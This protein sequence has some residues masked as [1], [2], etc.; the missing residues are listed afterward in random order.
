MK[1]MTIKAAWKY[2]YSTARQAARH[3]QIGLYYAETARIDSAAYYFMLASNDI[4]E[5][6]TGYRPDGSVY[7]CFS[8]SG[9]IFNVYAHDDDGGITKLHTFRFKFGDRT[10]ENNAARNNRRDWQIQAQAVER[11]AELRN[12]KRDIARMLNGMNDEDFFKAY[13]VIKA[14]VKTTR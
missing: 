10:P 13:N 7:T 14:A 8:S 2:C 11:I 12:A 4:R 6:N 5:A 9:F 1:K 3:Y